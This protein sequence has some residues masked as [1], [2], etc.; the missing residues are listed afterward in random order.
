MEGTEQPGA[1]VDVPTEWQSV[2]MQ[3]WSPDGW[4]VIT[5]MQQGSHAHSLKEPLV[6]TLSTRAWKGVCTGLLQSRCKLML[7]VIAL[8]LQLLEFSYN[9]QRMPPM[10]P[11]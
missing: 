6:P 4:F 10:L 3:V 2:Q 11:T 5:T 1:H 9:G 7:F 8:Y